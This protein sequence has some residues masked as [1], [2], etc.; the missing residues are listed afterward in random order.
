MLPLTTL[1]RRC[2]RCRGCCCAL[3]PLVAVAAAQVL[4]RYAH[5]QDGGEWWDAKADAFVAVGFDLDAGDVLLT[6]VIVDNNHP[7]WNQYLAFG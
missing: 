4:V 3:P 5:L 6:T 7:T 1:F 2:C